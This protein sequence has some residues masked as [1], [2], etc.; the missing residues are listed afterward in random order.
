MPRLGT[1]YPS[2]PWYVFPS[3]CPLP[4][5]LSPFLP[6]IS[7]FLGSLP[8]EPLLVFSALGIKFETCW[9]PT[10]PSLLDDSTVDDVIIHE[11]FQI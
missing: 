8:T 2:S 3:L 11:G 1:L 6:A 5:S 10:S 9:P 7:S 4:H